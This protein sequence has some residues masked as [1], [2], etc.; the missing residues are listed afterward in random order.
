M[1]GMSDT[2]NKHRRVYS[3]ARLKVKGT[4]SIVQNCLFA[5][6]LLWVSVVRV[7]ICDGCLMMHDVTQLLVGEC[8]LLLTL[9]I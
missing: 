3:G 7:F 5:F 9:F 6:P 8:Q 4:M 2:V 1:G